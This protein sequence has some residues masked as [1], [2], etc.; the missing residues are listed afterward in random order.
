MRVALLTGNA[1]AVL[2]VSGGRE[3]RG[4]WKW[5]E[6]GKGK[7]CGGGRGEGRDWRKG[8]RKEERYETKEVG[9]GKMGKEGSG[10]RWVRMG[11]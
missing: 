8:G 11:E 9:R 6:V 4:K 3:V 10:K 5:G 1:E 2:N 7:E